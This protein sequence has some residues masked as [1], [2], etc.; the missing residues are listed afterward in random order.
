MVGKA[1]EH[2]GGQILGVLR[3]VQQVEG[4]AEHEVGIRLVQRA[5][6]RAIGSSRPLDESFEG[7]G[8]AH[9]SHSA[10]KVAPTGTLPPPRSS[11]QSSAAYGAIMSGLWVANAKSVAVVMTPLDVPLRD[12][13][14]PVSSSSLLTANVD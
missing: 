7:Q 14:Y 11:T 10:E 3:A 13:V 5:E 6:R 8:S 4:R 12:A 2:V 1:D 9:G